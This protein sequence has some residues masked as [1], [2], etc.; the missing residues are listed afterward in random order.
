M[1][2][3]AP[4]ERQV[5]GPGGTPNPQSTAP[6]DLHP[7][8]RACLLVLL[9]LIPLRVVI[10]ESL[11]FEV[12]RLFRQLDV[13]DGA[14]PATTLAL[15]ALIVLVATVTA[16]V[17]WMK[18]LRRQARTGME[19]G[20]VVLLIAMIVSTLRAG[21]KHLAIIG[22][23]EMLGLIIYSVTLRRLLT[24][25][26]HVRLTLS[27]ILGAGAMTLVKCAYQKWIETPD[28]IRYFEAHRAELV[29]ENSAEAGSVDSGFLHDYEQRLRSGSVSGFFSHPNVLASYLIL[30]VM[31][32]VAVVMGRWGV[33][34]TWMLIAPCGIVVC[35]LFALVGAQS[36]GAAAAMAV[37]FAI[38]FLGR[39]L[40][41]LIARRPRATVVSVFLGGLLVAGALTVLL[42]ARP[43]ALGRSMLFRSLYW[44][45]A[46]N[47]MVDQGLWGIGAENFGRLFTRYKDVECPEDVDDP[48][49]WV[50]KSC[51]EWGVLGLVGFVMVLLG[52]AWRIAHGRSLMRGGDRPGGSIILWTGGIGAIVFTWWG[53]LV[54]GTTSEYAALVLHIPAITWVIMMIVLS[55][56]GRG[57]EFTDE[58]PGPVLIP[59]CAG[60]LGFLLHSGID[61]AMFNGGAATTFFAIVAVVIAVA[62]SGEKKAENVALAARRSTWKAGLVVI[63][64]VI[65]LV[66][67]LRLVIPAARV[68]RSLRIGR[69]QSGETRW[70]AYVASPG[71]LAYRAAMDAYPLDATAVNELLEQLTMRV[72]AIEHV[73]SALPLVEIMQH[74]DP[75]NAAAWQHLATLRYQRFVLGHDAADM[76]ASLDATQK[77]VDAYPTSPT[78][79]LMLAD[80]FAKQADSGGPAAARAKAVEEFERA[81]ELDDQQVYVSQPHHFSEAMKASIQKR[82]EQ[83]RAG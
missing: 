11:T 64:A 62:G 4:H 1:S 49:S 30:I 45:G 42:N 69:L 77:A 33:R 53:C 43:E 79:R 15:F 31:T 56:D 74:R 17:D 72:S 75:N 21:Q 39:M 3:G 46:A 10:A 6:T 47:M 23:L 38:F 5:S 59:L 83:L 7:I 66:V 40:R 36:K 29:P 71:Y 73:E 76:Q 13:P 82:I 14:G 12:P 78:K 35:G 18:G 28:T 70:G 26:W 25:P 8:H 37:S 63:G 60:I 48:H 80:L 52:G 20:A 68:G 44:R 55:L 22:S 24:S 34:P 61:L 41:G 57:R 32:S 81:L 19:I 2:R 54:S 16:A 27:V 67:S 51:V 58:S 50:V 9:A 65:V